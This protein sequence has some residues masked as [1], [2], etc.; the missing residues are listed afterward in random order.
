MRT[1]EL[2]LSKEERESLAR[3]HPE[4]KTDAHII[5]ACEDLISEGDAE[6][7]ND[8]I[9]WLTELYPERKIDEKEIK[10]KIAILKEIENRK[11]N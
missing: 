10:L 5:S 1:N 3:R 7:F 8:A 2:N 9:N 11:K 4:L 6:D